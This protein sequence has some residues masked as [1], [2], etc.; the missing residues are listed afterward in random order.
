MTE[1]ALIA[2]SPGRQAAADGRVE[3]QRATHGVVAG[4]RQGNLLGIALPT[5]AE[6]GALAMRRVEPLLATPFKGSMACCRDAALED[7]DFV[8]EH[9]DLEE[10]P[11]RRVRHAVEITATLAMPSCEARRCRSKHRPIGR[12]RQGLQ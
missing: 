7:A 11:P 3:V 5:L 4:A 12:A 9:M 2:R 6:A 1:E 10:P 8:G